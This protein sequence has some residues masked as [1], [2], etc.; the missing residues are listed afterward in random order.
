MEEPV[1]KMV[2]RSHTVYINKYKQYVRVYN[3]L[4]EADWM[5]DSNRLGQAVQFTY[6]W[7]EEVDI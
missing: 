2:K 4:I 1:K 6:E 3:T 5:A 7:E